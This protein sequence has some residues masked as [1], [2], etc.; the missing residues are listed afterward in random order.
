EERWT[1]GSSPRVTSVTRCSCRGLG[2]LP[3]PF[4]GEGW[5]GGNS[6]SLQPKS[7]VSDFGRSMKRPNSG[8]P[9]FGCKRGG[10]GTEFAG[11]RGRG[12]AEGARSSIPLAG[13][14]WGGGGMHALSFCMPPPCPSPACGGG[15]AGPAHV[16]LRRRQALLPRPGDREIGEDL[17]LL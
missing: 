10:G 12:A 3:P 9:E 2:L 16:R 5:G 7:D 17:I 13:E 14:G 4:T 1:R 6:L 15:D 11:R 8:E